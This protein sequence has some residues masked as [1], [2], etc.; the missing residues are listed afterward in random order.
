MSRFEPTAA[1]AW[2]E[3]LLLG[4]IWGGS[5]LSARLVLDEVPVVTTVFYRVS[6]GCVAL[7]IW[8][9]LRRLPVPRDPNVWGAFLIMGILNNVL[10]FG[11][12]TWGQ[13]HIESG[14]VAILNATTAVFGVLVAAMVFADER[15]TLRRIL[16]VVLGLCGVAVCVGLD[17]LATLD[18]RSV[19]QLAVIGAAV[20]YAFASSWGRARLVGLAPEVAAAGMLTCSALVLL[21]VTLVH[22]GLPSADL[23]LR[24]LGAIAYLSLIATAGAYLLYYRVLAA[25]GA[26]TLMLVTLVVPP[27]AILLGAIVL[28]EALPPRAFGGFALLALGLLTLS[29]VLP[30]PGRKR[31][32]IDR[33][34]PP[35]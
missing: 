22:D 14:L 28:D 32:A 9:A 24:T 7:W 4:L 1:R 12:L 16:G 10:P 8:V 18:L 30:L 21:P 5:F 15:L 6:G 11:L 31:R 29:G 2:A 17:A 3:L 27:V 35:R 25:A 33:R 20:S 23:S 26:G 19:A 13:V 34:P